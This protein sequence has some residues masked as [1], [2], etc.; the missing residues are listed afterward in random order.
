MQNRRAT[1]TYALYRLAYLL[2]NAL[3]RS[4]SL[5]IATRLADSYWRRADQER[6]MIRDNLRLVLREPLTEW[7]PMVREVFRNFATYLAEF[8]IA[9]R[10]TAAR[11]RLEGLEETQERLRAHMPCIALSAHLGNWEL[12]ALLLRRA[13]LPMGAVALSHLNPRV[14]RLFD[15]QRLRGGVGVIP[16]GFRAS[17]QCMTWLRNGGVL[18]IVGDRNFGRRG[19]PVRLFGRDVAMPP[20]PAMLSLRSGAPLVPI[21]LIREAPWC[22]RFY[23]E[24]AIVPPRGRWTSSQ[25]TELTQRYTDVLAQYV[26]RFPSQWLMFQR[27]EIGSSSHAA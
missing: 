25:V 11:I 26:R 16:L 15:R 9:H 8:F 6:R 23:S 13:G 7:A 27:L 10:L 14:N 3:P 22:F 2:A 4:W 20:G 21:F 17:T 19:I 18:G 12:G 5:H 1:Q 24:E